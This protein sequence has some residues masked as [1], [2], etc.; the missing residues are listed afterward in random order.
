[1]WGA[2]KEGDV[3]GWAWFPVPGEI[4]MRC[5]GG[6]WGMES[7]VSVGAAMVKMRRENWGGV[8][9][10]YLYPA[11]TISLFFF[12]L[13]KNSHNM[14]LTINFFFKFFLNFF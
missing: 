2:H 13:R 12:K 3:D 8:W 9:C 10:M 4:L 14:K 1:M 11:L 5:G 7:G 6:Q